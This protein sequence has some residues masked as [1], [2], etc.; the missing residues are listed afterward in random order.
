VSKLPSIANEKNAKGIDRGL[1]A[2][3]VGLAII[4]ALTGA[5]ENLLGMFHRVAA[6]IH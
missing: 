6:S 2:D 3:L 5:G 1:I 4:A